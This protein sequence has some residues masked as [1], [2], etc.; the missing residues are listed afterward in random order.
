MATIS[1]LWFSREEQNPYDCR[2]HA[3]GSTLTARTYLINAMR[4][5]NNLSGEKRAEEEEEAK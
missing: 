2:A 4:G 5:R 3:Y 1:S